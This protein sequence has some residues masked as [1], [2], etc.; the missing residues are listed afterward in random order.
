MI[1]ADRRCSSVRRALVLAGGG[2]RGAYQVGMLQELV[3]NRGLDFQIIRGVSVGA[4]NAA[5]LAQAPSKSDSL[6]E[7]RTKVEILRK[8][9]ME[10]IEGARSVYGKREGLLG[11]A[12][13]A[14]SLYSLDPLKQLI[15]KNVSLKALR[16]SGR[17]FAVGTVSLI[18]GTYK[19][20]NPTDR[21]FV[22]KILA[23][24]SIP[25]V[26]PYVDL[27]T[28]K[29]V[30]VDGG[31]RNITP[32][33]SAFDANPDEIYILLTSRLIRKGSV[34][35]ASG[36]MEHA[37]SQ[38]SDN[39]LGTKIK[40]LDVLKRCVEILTD[41]VYLE[42]IRGAL[43]WN[44]MAEGV[45]ELDQIQAKHSIPDEVNRAIQKVVRKMTKLGK[46]YAP[47][48]V[49]APREWYGEENDATE[50]TPPLIRRAIEH[51]RAVAAD[52]RLWLW[53]PKQKTY[54]HGSTEAGKL[55]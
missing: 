43:Q 13:G 20:W 35:P 7:L 2:A 49:L 41:E 30:L 18:S 50:F 16:M 15:K 4:L 42:D 25:V 24:A 12:G 51:G 37:Y 34:F 14:D 8:V 1:T 3:L 48:F 54:H 38:W 45:I 27:K 19:E 44:E 29:D 33:S 23:S 17:N 52:P 31:V 6:S 46:R 22:E 55:E 40:G 28:D 9:W 36:V 39:W 10:E 32:L 53:P 47:L 26:F 21:H 11:L 5:F